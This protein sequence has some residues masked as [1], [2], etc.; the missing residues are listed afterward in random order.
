VDVQ[1]I[2]DVPATQ[3]AGVVEVG[4]CV[5]VHHLLKPVRGSCLTCFGKASVASVSVICTVE[6]VRSCQ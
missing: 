3:T 6:V 5:G 2:G 1:T 4:V